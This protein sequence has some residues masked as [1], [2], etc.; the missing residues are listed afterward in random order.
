MLSIGRIYHNESL[1]SETFIFTVSHIF[2][3]G[4]AREVFLWG[5]KTI[6]WASAYVTMHVVKWYLLW[7]LL[8]VYCFGRGEAQIWGCCLGL[9]PSVTTC[10]FVIH[11]TEAL[12]IQ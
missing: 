4:G 11:C 1:Q 7:C 6:L 8:D 2:F 5:E 3:G 10:R 12:H 9:R